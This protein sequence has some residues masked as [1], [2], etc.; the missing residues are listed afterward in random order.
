MQDPEQK[1]SVSSAQA[2]ADTAPASLQSEIVPSA[3]DTP[4]QAPLAYSD[5][6]AP[7]LGVLL[8]RR[9]QQDPA[10]LRAE[11]ATL[12]STLAAR[13]IAHLER[14]QRLLE[15]YCH[16]LQLMLPEIERE[17]H[18]ARIRRTALSFALPT[19]RDTLGSALKSLTTATL[20]TMQ[21]QRTVLGVT[22]AKPRE[23]ERGQWLDLSRLDTAAL[24]QVREAIQLLAGSCK[25]HSAPPVPPEPLDDLRFQLDPPPR[26]ER[27]P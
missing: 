7:Q 3:G 26:D 25:H 13:Q 17:A 27:G 8:P 11:L 4:L 20:I 18:V 2:N 5:G 15:D 6:A 21:L 12:R 19:E 14:H 9:K 23:E 24:A 22:T 1:L 10:K 16:L